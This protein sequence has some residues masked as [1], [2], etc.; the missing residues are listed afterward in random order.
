M[1]IFRDESHPVKPACPIPLRPDPPDPV[2]IF[3][4]LVDAR[5]RSDRS[6]VGPL[7]VALRRLGWSVHAI[8]PVGKGARS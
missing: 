8:A 7:Q 6:A 4:R 2:G 5:R 3:A 1:D